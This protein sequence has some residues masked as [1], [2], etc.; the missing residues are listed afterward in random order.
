MK[1]FAKLAAVVL[2]AASMSSYAAPIASTGAGLSVIVSGTSHVIATYEGTSASYSN[3]LYLG[4]RLLFN[5]HTTAVGTFID[6]GSYAVGTELIF[7][8]EVVNTANNFFTG[9]ALRNPD[10]HAHARVQSDYLDAGT[11]LVSFEDL[12]NGPYDYNDLSF[13][14]TN[15]TAAV[16]L[17]NNVPEPG[18]LALRSLGLVGLV[19]Q[20][21]R[22]QR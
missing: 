13:T 16:N 19:A 11:T 7:R 22:K 5:N 4:N 17:A 2:A 8:L 14:F 6:L 20:G 15:T 18:S 9:A 21:K 12:F 3:N 1:N 10:N